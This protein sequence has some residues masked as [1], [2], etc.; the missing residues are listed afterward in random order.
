MSRGGCLLILCGMLGG[1]FGPGAFKP[2]PPYYQSWIKEGADELDIKKKIL[3]C[4]DSSPAGGNQTMNESALVHLCMVR[5]GYMP[6]KFYSKEIADPDD[7]CRNWPELPAC[8][9]GANIP[10]P[11]LNRRLQSR[12]C[13]IRS[14]S[15]NCFA[16]TGPETPFCKSLS[17]EKPFPECLP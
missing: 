2:S 5:S 3:E 9:S 8:Q 4:G 13:R 11:D 1:C 10:A 7:W 15:E 12:Y 16:L 14:S 6:Y 17:F